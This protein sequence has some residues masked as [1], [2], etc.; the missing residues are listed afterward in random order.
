VGQQVRQ[1]DAPVEKHGHYQP[2]GIASQVAA[3]TGLSVRTVQRALN[4]QPNKFQN[5]A[6]GDSQNDARKQAKKKLQE[7]QAAREAAFNTPEAR[8][9]QWTEG[10]DHMWRIFHG[11]PTVFVV[12]IPPA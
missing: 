2:K 12:N 4:P 6:G 5:L 8:Y 3:E 1:S 10:M 9:Q 7:M 11:R